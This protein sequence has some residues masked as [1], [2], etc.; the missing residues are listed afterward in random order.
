MFGAQFLASAG[1][2]VTSGI[3]AAC[4]ANACSS[5]TLQVLFGEVST[6]LVYLVGAVAVIFII[7]GG[8][9]YVTSNGNEKSV[10]AAKNTL[11]YAVIG[12]V[13]AIASYAIVQFVLTN[14]K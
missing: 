5:S 14:I 1:S 10:E 4:S 8:L 12:L 2:Q 11:L 7:I 3:G 6:L 13:V 9:R